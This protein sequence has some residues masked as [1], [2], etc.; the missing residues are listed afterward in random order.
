LRAAR[1]EH[2][3]SYLKVARLAGLSILP[4]PY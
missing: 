1:V 3:H 2:H 4:R